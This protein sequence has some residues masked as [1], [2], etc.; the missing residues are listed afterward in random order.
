[1]DLKS[2]IDI[3]RI[4]GHIAFIMDG[5]GR[6]A[7]KRGEARIF[8]HQE[9]V[10]SVRKIATTAA[11]LGVRHITMYAFSTENWKR[12]QFE[13]DALMDIL[14]NSLTMELDTLMKNNIR[15]KA[16][17]DLSGLNEGCRNQLQQ[18]MQATS[19]NN[20]MDLILAI[21]YSGRWEITEAARKIA[22]EVKQ[23]NLNVDDINSG[24]VNDYL[25]TAGL[26]EP[27]LLIRTGGENRVSNFLLW[28]IAYSELYI[29][30]TFWPDFRENQLYEAI[31]D[32][33]NRERRFGMISEQINQ[34]LDK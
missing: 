19:V 21:N 32:F 26:P 12:P 15:L 9:G 34:S 2:K 11:E 7:K 30:D 13:V 8:G 27:E 33:Q 1:M 24:T 31:I 18:T 28:Q 5:N 17:G 6:W 10:E 22:L 20:R 23:G 4:P 14:V 29:T 16:I 3:S 25:S